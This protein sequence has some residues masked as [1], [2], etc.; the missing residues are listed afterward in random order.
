MKSSA[1]ELGLLKQLLIS[2]IKCTGT[3]IIQTP[4]GCAIVSVTYRWVSVH[5]VFSVRSKQLSGPL[6]IQCVKHK[7]RFLRNLLS[8]VSSQLFRPDL[9]FQ[10]LIIL[11]AMLRSR[12]EHLFLIFAAAGQERKQQG[13]RNYSCS[14]WGLFTSI[15]STLVC[16][17]LALPSLQSVVLFVPSAVTLTLPQDKIASTFGRPPLPPKKRREVTGFFCK[18]KTLS[19]VNHF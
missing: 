5:R 11:N 10:F 6:Q 14:S 7:R 4:R 9:L 18:R 2:L 17:E 3:Q 19:H 12:I 8:F 1:T 13:Q 16:S 15:S